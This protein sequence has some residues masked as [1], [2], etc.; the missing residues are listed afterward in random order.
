M[1]GKDP[2]AAVADW[3]GG[4]VD[5]IRD[6]TFLQGLSDVMRI[7][8]ANNTVVAAGRWAS[9]FAASWVPNIVRGTARA[10]DDQIRENRIW[11]KDSP[12][13]WNRALAATLDGAFPAP[14]L[15][16]PPKVDV[17]G[18]PIEKASTGGP[19]TTFAYRM[20]AP[21]NKIEVDPFV[22]DVILYRWNERHPND[23]MQITPAMPYY[24]REING[25]SVRID[26]TPDE[27][28]DFLVTSGTIAR[29][30][31]QSM[32]DKGSITTDMIDDPPRAI[33]DAMGDILSK[34]RQAARDQHFG[35]MIQAMQ[36]AGFTSDQIVAQLRGEDEPAVSASGSDATGCTPGSRTAGRSP[37]RTCPTTTSSR[38]R[39]TPD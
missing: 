6:K 13:F 15:A 18:R 32:V 10:T 39:P 25:K 28:H 34:T 11:C 8:D 1:D 24:R 35:A 7:F 2:S 16:N 22:G 37:T 31:I 19:A 12:A 21:A 33:A 9:G 23:E 29:E 20:L 36:D 26:M 27:Y 38:N 3:L 4:F 30:A 14:F 17:W 5:Q